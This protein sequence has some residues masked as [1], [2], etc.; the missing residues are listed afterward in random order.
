MANDPTPVKPWGKADKKIQHLIYESKVDIGRSSDVRYI[1]RISLK[2]VRE[3]DVPNFCRNFRT[4]AQSHELEDQISGYQQRQGEY[5]IF[6]NPTLFPISKISANGGVSLEDVDDNTTNDSKD[7]NNAATN[8]G[9]NENMPRAIAFKNTTAPTKKKG[10]SKTTGEEDPI[11]VDSPI[12]RKKQHA[13]PAC[14]FIN[15]P[16]GYTVNPYVQGLKNKIDIILHKGGFP[17]RT[18]SPK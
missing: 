18:P 17:R 11:N 4:C 10:G 1:N 5:L 2:Y 16:Q 9:K 13:M 14:F 15:P 6:A 12:P 7:D 8:D 3:R